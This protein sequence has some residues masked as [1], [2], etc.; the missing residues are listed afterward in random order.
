MAK[1]CFIYNIYHLVHI[2][3]STDLRRY[4][5]PIPQY[6]STDVRLILLVLHVCHVV[7]IIDDY[8]LLVFLQL[9]ILLLIFV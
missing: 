1:Q 7:P 3:L 6:N 9:P 4:E 8:V 5:R 2:Y